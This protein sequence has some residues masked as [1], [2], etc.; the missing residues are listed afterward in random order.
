MAAMGIGLLGAPNIIIKRQFRFTVEIQTARSGL[1]P[2]WF[3]KLANRPQLEIDAT[4]INF[5]NAVTWIPGKARWQPLTITY[6][7]VANSLTKP[8]YDWV[9]TV[10]DH[11]KIAQLPMSEKCGWAGT[12]LIRMWD[13]CGSLLETWQL[14]SAFPS[15]INFGSLDYAS[16][17]DA[18]I[19][20]TI[21]YSEAQ[22][23]GACGTPTPSGSCCGC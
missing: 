16:S 7:D 1:I 8:L 17:E 2:I 9:A 6:I 5:R 13:G 19:E 11:M 21:R 15:G 10:Y 12:V 18:T 20:L 3:V 23:F 4:E 14:G 22:L